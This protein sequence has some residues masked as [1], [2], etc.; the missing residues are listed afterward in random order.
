MARRLEELDPLNR[1]VHEP[2]RLVIMTALAACAS[3][4][5]VFLQRI[6]GLTNGNLS[7]HL[8]KLSEGGLVSIEKRFVNR[9]PNTR[10][11]LSSEGRR[12]VDEHWRQLEELRAGARGLKSRSR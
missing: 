1:L 5:F 3:A 9:K 4:D 6:T 11:V 2:A 10:V 7:A 8:N 12:A